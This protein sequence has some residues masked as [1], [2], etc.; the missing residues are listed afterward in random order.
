MQIFKPLAIACGCTDWFVSDLVRNPEDRFS[1]DAGCL[2]QE[3]YKGGNNVFF[4]SSFLCNAC[5][6]L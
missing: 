3:K 5:T 4:S 1:N 6:S 2:I